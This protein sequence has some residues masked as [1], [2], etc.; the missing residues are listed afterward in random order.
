MAM[1]GRG[2]PVSAGFDLSA[3]R[4]LDSRTWCQ[5]HAEMENMPA[6]RKFQGLKTYVIDEDVQYKWNGSDWVIDHTGLTSGSGSPVASTGATGDIYIDK[7][8]GDVWYKV[9]NRASETIEWS[10]MF[11]IT[12]P[13][14]DQGDTGPKGT[15]GSIW[16]SGTACTGTDTAGVI[17]PST[18]ITQSNINDQ[19][20]N[21]M[22]GNVYQCI[23]AGSST[24]AE[25]TDIHY[26][27]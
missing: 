14:G 9:F 22:T 27:S 20:L 12:G 26:L 8:N 5:N 23:V 25:Y 16:T 18:G 6:V 11:N 19:Y 15:R 24:I 13:K 7:S 2:I 1:F 17:F 10:L 4:P 21:I 3:R